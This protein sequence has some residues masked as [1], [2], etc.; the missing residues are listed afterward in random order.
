MLFLVMSLLFVLPL[1]LARAVREFVVCESVSVS[2]SLRV[3]LRLPRDA[4]ADDD[5]MMNGADGG[6]VE[7]EDGW[8]AVDEMRRGEKRRQ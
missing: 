8:P 4:R 3:C 5:F 7:D 2:V 6:C 1:S